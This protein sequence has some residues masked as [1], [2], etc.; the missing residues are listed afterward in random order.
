[1]KPLLDNGDLASVF[2]LPPNAQNE[3]AKIDFE[4]F[5]CPNCPE[6]SF[7]TIKE[8]L[9]TRNKKGEVEEKSKTLIEQALLTPDLADQFTARIMV[10]NHGVAPAA[11]PA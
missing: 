7:L 5:Y 10:G 6:T 4:R 1:M 9:S 8:T 3:N 2:A 11:S